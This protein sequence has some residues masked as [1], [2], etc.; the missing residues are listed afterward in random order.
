M[1]SSIIHIARRAVFT[2]LIL[3]AVP[4]AFSQGA[5]QPERLKILVPQS[6]SAIPFLRMA[7]E[8]PL[9]GTIIQAEPFASHP[10]ALALL[11][12][13]EAD[14]LLTGTSQGW[15]NRLDGSPIIMVD[16]GI[17]GISS[18]IGKDA[19][20]STVAA[21]KGKRIALPF[22]G[23][24]L[25]FQT[26]ALLA[27]EK[28]DADHDVSLIYGAFTQSIPRLLAGQL[29]AVALPEPQATAMVKERGLVRLMKYADAWARAYGGDGRSPQVSLFVTQEFAKKHAA[30][31]RDLVSVWAAATTEVKRDPAAAAAAYAGALSTDAP[32]LEEALRNTLFD[33][34]S[35][36][37]NRELVMGYYKT[38]S[39]YF[40]Q[41]RGALDEGFFFQP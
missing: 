19:G 39:P 25:D 41:P 18:L 3:T 33:V 35:F 1:K 6:T 13:G 9:P 27:A 34:P 28:L 40:P 4:S 15:E 37:Q 29:D 2:A 26:R 14:M 8:N 31:I 32:T 7:R 10:Q 23:S 21:L 17:W 11:L 36:P 30:L 38:V 20:L 12:R 16:T 22:P 5:Q 24:P